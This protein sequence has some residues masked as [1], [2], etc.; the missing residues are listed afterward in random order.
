MQSALSPGSG[1]GP[2]AFPCCERRV[3]AI[4]AATGRPAAL[5][6]HFAYLL[7]TAAVAAEK[8]RMQGKYLRRVRTAAGR[9]RLRP[10]PFPLFRHRLD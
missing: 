10:R 6:M 1:P 9:N 3:E 7:V 5:D 8:G 4:A 2:G